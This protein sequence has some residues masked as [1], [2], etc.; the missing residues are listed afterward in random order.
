MLHDDLMTAGV[1]QWDDPPPED[2]GM[3]RLQLDSQGRLLYFERIPPQRADARQADSADGL[4][5]AV[6]RGGTGPIHNSNRRSRSGLR[7]RHRTHARP[8]PEGRR[9]SSAW[10]RRRFAGSRCSSRS[11]EPWTKPDR[12]PGASDSTMVTVTFSVLGAVLVVVIVAAALLAAGNL[13][14]QRGDRR[15]AFRLAAFVFFVQMALWASRAHIMR[16]VRHVRHV[17]DGAGDVRHFMAW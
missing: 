11:I 10:R 2:S 7:W 5:R 14:R 9:G 15:G 13:R 4:E 16:F 3:V 6:C 8:G 17:S 1:V 12:T